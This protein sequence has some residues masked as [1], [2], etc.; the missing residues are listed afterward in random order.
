[1]NGNY[2]LELFIE[3]S[4]ST[5]PGAASE[6]EQWVQG[7]HLPALVSSEW[8]TE[9][10]QVYRNV[11]TEPAVGQ[12]RFLTISP[13]D[14]WDIDS[15][16]DVIE[17]ELQPAWRAAGEL[18]ERFAPIWG[19]CYRMCGPT[20]RPSS[21]PFVTERTGSA[22]VTAIM[23]LQ[24]SCPRANENEL[25]RWYNRVRVP[26][27]V[28][29]GPFHTGYRYCSCRFADPKRRF[30]QIFETDAAN[31]AAEIEQFMADW[32]PD[33][34]EPPFAEDLGISIFSPV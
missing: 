20:M 12:G 5:E 27:L 1:M 9:P 11:L 3:L 22:P 30:L 26:E 2:P 23:V 4:D 10:G 13:A 33:S 16:A 21:S 19:D 34:V 18:D 32:R 7:V 8:V 31:P 29:A 28:A 17:E 6:V 25:N 24:S 15:I 14:R